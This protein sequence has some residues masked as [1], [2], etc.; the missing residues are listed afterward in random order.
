MKKIVLSAAL[1]LSSIGLQAQQKS[2]YNQYDLFHPLF[3]YT[4]STPSRSG[5]GAPGSAYWQ[6]QADYKISVN[7]DDEKNTLEGEVEITYKNASPDKLNF[8]WLQLDQNQ[9]SDKSRA[10]A[11]TTITGG[12]F[13][14][15]GTNGGYDIKSVSIDGKTVD[16]L[17]SD[18]RL[19]IKLSTPILE[20]TGIAKIK[21]NYSYHPSF[22]YYHHTL[23][24]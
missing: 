7:L 10:T 23:L 2:T 3:N 16:F 14:N 6:N 15:T 18:T 5:T 22:P 9:F 19:Q 8:L 20:R 11:A 1:L 4:L 21:I 12:R 17:V 13:G 24:S